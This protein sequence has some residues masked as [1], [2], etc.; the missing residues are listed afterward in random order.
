MIHGF[1]DKLIS[2]ACGREIPLPHSP[3]QVVTELSPGLR[4]AEKEILLLK[5][6]TRLG[7]SL[8]ALLTRGWSFSTMNSPYHLYPQLACLRIS[9]LNF[10]CISRSDLKCEKVMLCFNYLLFRK[11]T[12]NSKWSTDN[13]R[14]SGDAQLWRELSFLQEIGQSELLNSGSL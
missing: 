9:P 7:W 13:H 10:N 14:N 3:I 6:S 4:K 1:E 2:T 8:R 12:E 5:P 11:R